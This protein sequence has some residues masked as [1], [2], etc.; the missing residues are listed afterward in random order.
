[1]IAV[2]SPPSAGN[3]LSVVI[4]PRPQPDL[5]FVDLCQCDKRGGGGGRGRRTLYK[6]NAING[7][8]VDGTPITQENL[9]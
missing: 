3:G 9:N 4:A 2:V 1:M 6:N 8:V 7:N 5:Q